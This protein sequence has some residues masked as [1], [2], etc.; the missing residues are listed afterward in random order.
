MVPFLERKLSYRQ[1]RAFIDHVESC[2]SCG[3]EF[4]VQTLV[5]QGI[6]S[7]DDGSVFDL[8]A[9]IDKREMEAHRQ[10]RNHRFVTSLAWTLNLLAVVTAVAVLVYYLI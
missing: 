4:A 1:T 2:E 5:T 9:E 7:L 8:R 10:L 6:A 3:E